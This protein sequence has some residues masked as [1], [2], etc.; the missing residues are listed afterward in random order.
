MWGIIDKKGKLVIPYKY[1]EI[2]HLSEGCFRVQDAVT[3]KYGF[4]NK[5]DKVVVPLKYSGAASAFSDGLVIVYQQ[6]QGVGFV[7]AQGKEQIP[8]EYHQAHP[9][10][11]GAAPVRKGDKWGF[12]L[13][14]LP[15]LLKAITC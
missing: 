15:L 4:I 11:Q 6:E 10:N 3:G 1:S 5:A 7:N 9:F 8:L 2:S 13:P 14:R 12:I